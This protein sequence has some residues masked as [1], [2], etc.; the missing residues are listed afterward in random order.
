M[1]GRPPW[2]ADWGE[3]AWFFWTEYQQASH[4]MQALASLI[5]RVLGP[6]TA[7]APVSLSATDARREALAWYLQSLSAATR[8]RIARDNFLLVRDA[9]I[10]GVP[11]ARRPVSV[12]GAETITALCHRTSLPSDDIA[13]RQAVTLLVASLGELAPAAAER[14]GG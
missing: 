7:D 1:A 12:E 14:R 11:V 2:A 10:S 9:G 6:P 8:L 13:W 3:D 5:L 4:D